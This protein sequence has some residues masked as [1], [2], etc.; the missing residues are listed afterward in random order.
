M[1]TRNKDYYTSTIAASPF[2][3]VL[4]PRVDVTLENLFVFPQI[5]TRLVIVNMQNRL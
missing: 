4:V 3:T 5:R 2:G 1:S